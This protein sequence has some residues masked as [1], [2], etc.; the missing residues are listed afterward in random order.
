MAI[1]ATKSLA[2]RAESH[3]GDAGQSMRRTLY[4]YAAGCLARTLRELTEVQRIAGRAAVER[5]YQLG[6]LF[7]EESC[8]GQAMHT[9]MD[10]VS[11]GEG[12]AA[13]AVPHRGHLI[14]LGQPRAWEWLLE[15]LTGHPLVLTSRAP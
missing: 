13:V 3:G 9:L 6:P 7:V 4:C 14:P 1:A 5:G 15:E 11:A 8:A 12:T 10:A 2:L